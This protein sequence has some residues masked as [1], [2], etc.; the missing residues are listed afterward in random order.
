M[1][2]KVSLVHAHTLVHTHTQ[3]DICFTEEDVYAPKSKVVSEFFG[4]R[5]MS[6]I[7]QHKLAAQTLVH[8]LGL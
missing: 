2:E 8:A 1:T 7:V 5:L 3:L 6:P 4:S